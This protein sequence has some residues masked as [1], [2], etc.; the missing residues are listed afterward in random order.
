MLRIV[1]S[2]KMGRY[3]IKRYKIERIESLKD[4]IFDMY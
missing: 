2:E 1:S 3:I 4:T